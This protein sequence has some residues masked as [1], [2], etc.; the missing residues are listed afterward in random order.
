MVGNENLTIS[1]RFTRE[2]KHV[3]S[4]KNLIVKVLKFLFN[5]IEIHRNLNYV[6]IRHIHLL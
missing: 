5:S 6:Q 1:I 4:D 2:K 3:L